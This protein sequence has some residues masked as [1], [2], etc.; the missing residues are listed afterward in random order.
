MASLIC[1][2]FA[3]TRVALAETT[4]RSP[5]P[6]T[7]TQDMTGAWSKSGLMSMS[8]TDAQRLMSRWGAFEF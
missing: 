3:F 1:A 6:L 4:L 8:W 7:E 2:G 5:V